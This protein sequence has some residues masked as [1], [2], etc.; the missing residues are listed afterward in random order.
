M[1]IIPVKLGVW[2][3]LSS[4]G[5]GRLSQNPWK[6]KIALE[7]PKGYS[8]LITHPLNRYDLPFTTMSAIV[9]ADFGLHGGQ[10]PFFLK[11]NFEGIIPMGTPIAQIIPFKRDNWI[12]EKSLGLW[13]KSDLNNKRAYMVTS[14]WYKKN[15]WKKKSFE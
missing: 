6:F 1:D 4:L 9:D 14:G 7:V 2:P 11:E 8:F 3:G 15:H 10:V 12:S 5:F 13:K